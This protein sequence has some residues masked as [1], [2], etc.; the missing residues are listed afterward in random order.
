M[1]C[2]SARIDSFDSWFRGLEQAVAEL[3]GQMS[4]VGDFVRGCNQPQ[5]ATG[6]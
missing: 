3:S 6:D 1:D 2:L 5:E 4:M